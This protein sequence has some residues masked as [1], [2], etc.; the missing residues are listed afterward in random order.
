MK[1]MGSILYKTC[2]IAMVVFALYG[3]NKG[4]EGVLKDYYMP[5]LQTGEETILLYNNVGSQER[6]E[7]WHIHKTWGGYVVTVFDEG[8]ELLQRS[9]ETENI[10]GIVQADVEIAWQDPTPNIIWIDS[11][12]TSPDLFP[13]NPLD[14]SYAY[15]HCINWTREY[16]KF[17]LCRN[18]RYLGKVQMAWKGKTYEAAQF[19][20]MELYSD[21]EQGFL[22]VEVPGIEYYAPG[23]GLIYKR[24]KLSESL[25]FTQELLEV[26]TVDEFYSLYGNLARRMFE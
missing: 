20:L 7:Y 12:I 16:R 10:D 18:R 8:G 23:L 24:K 17:E 5:R 22:E 4:S 21:E 3:C 14:S 13:F 2:I 25:D 19:L 9:T 1:F 15:V 11:E 26:Y 6:L